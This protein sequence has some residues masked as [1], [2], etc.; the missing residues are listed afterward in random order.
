MGVRVDSE[1]NR[2][3]LIFSENM[4]YSALGIRYEFRVVSTC[5]RV[6]WFSFCI[7]ISSLGGKLYK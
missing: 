3:T 2:N 1:V 5:G 4:Y 6:T 7:K